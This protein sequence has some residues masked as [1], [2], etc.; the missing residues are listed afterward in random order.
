[1]TVQE[2]LRWASSFLEERK[3][4]P[5]VAEWLIR[6]YLQV[7]RTKL[8]TML[9]DPIEPKWID[10]LE[11][12]L[13]EHAKG[14]PVQHLIGY[15]EF[16]GRRFAVNKHVLIPR[17]ETE[18]L[19]VAVGQLAAKLFRDEQVTVVDVGTGSG[20]I[21]ITLALEHPTFEVNAIDISEEALFVAQK[22]AKNLEADV[23]FL[24]GDL[25]QPLINQQKKVKLIVS[26]PPYIPL[27]DAEQLAVHVRD[28]E[29]HLALFGGQDGLDLYRRFMTEL[30]Q[31][32]EQTGI[33]AFEVGINQARIVEAMLA[34]AFPYA[35]TEIRNDISGKERMVFA[36]G[37]MS[38]D[39][40]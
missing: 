37:D 10:Q 35:T 11:H 2:A 23:H 38:K 32:I 8:F 30:P 9:Q 13:H 33:I 16:F 14:V 26:N 27:T 25:L 12:D 3:L 4:E 19:V 17:P 15:E 24:K 7:N 39:E 34:K 18:E 40:G 29:P 6:H 5:P 1:M 21:S 22:N 20:A 36:Y 28:H 31:V